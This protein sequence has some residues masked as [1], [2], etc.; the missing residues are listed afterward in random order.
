MA[1][2]PRWEIFAAHLDL[3]ALRIAG[4]IGAGSARRRAAGGATAGRAG[5]GPGA[6]GGAPLSGARPGELDR[7]SFEELFPW[8]AGWASAVLAEG[9]WCPPVPGTASPTRNSPTGCRAATSTSTRRCARLCTS[10]VRRSTG[11]GDRTAPGAPPDGTGRTLP[12]PRHRIGPVLQALLLLGRRAGPDALARRLE[13]LV[14]VVDR[15]AAARR[16]PRRRA[17]GRTRRRSLVRARRRPPAWTRKRAPVRTP[18]RCGGPRACWGDAAQGHRRHAVPP[19]A[20]VAGPADH[21]AFAGVRRLPGRRDGRTVGGLAEFGAWFWLRL[22]LAPADR[23]ALLRLLIPAD[24]PPRG[25]V[26]SGRG[27][28]RDRVSGRGRDAGGI[29]ER[30]GEGSGEAA[31]GRF[32]SVAAELLAE[33]PHTVQPLLCRWFDDERL[34]PGP[35]D[36]HAAG[37]DREGA[38]RGAAVPARGQRPDDAP[39]PTVAAVAQAL[40][41]THRRRAVD[42][43]PRR[44]SPPRTPRGRTP[45]RAR[46]G[47]ALGGVP[48][49]GPLGA[50]RAGGAP[51]RRGVVRAAGRGPGGLR[52]RPRAAAPRGITLLARPVEDAPHAARR[53]VPRSPCSYATR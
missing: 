10:G 25:P 35:P 9:C 1:P 31:G 4:R 40:L 45:R 32:L 27:R 33:D 13:D 36:Q 50:R 24:G 21:G 6:R 39:R 41:H 14:R 26:R 38:G 46:R 17:P 34:L 2:P 18:K 12:V 23:L 52:H 7:A 29:G 3:V 19:G 47:R 30:S 51:G 43:L 5:G 15:S 22:R 8:G 44:S 48:R 28:G 53:T 11:V 42:A 16:R 49:G 20:G 37:P